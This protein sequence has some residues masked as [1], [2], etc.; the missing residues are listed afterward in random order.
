MYFL[1]NLLL[2]YGQL[3]ILIA[4]DNLRGDARFMFFSICKQG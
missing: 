1:S 2:D 3:N 4:G